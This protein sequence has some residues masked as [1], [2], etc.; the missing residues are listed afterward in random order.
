MLSTNQSPTY[1][2]ILLWIVN[3]FGLRSRIHQY[4][5][6]DKIGGSETPAEEKEEEEGED[7]YALKN[8]NIDP[9]LPIF[10]DFITLSLQIFMGRLNEIVLP[11]HLITGAI[12]EYEP[13]PNLSCQAL[14][15]STAGGLR[16]RNT[17]LRRKPHFHRFMNTLDKIYKTLQGGI[18]LILSGIIFVKYFK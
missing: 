18:S 8:Y 17:W 15:V 1:D 3:I 11:P 5:D 10:N 9:F 14:T 4:G 6:K 2:V 13:I 12:L 16:P 7:F